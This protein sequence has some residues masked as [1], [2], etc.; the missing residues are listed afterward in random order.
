MRDNWINSKRSDMYNDEN[1]V[2]TFSNIYSPLIQVFSGSQCLR[3]NCL[4][5]SWMDVQYVSS[6]FF[7][8]FFFFLILAFLD[9]S[10]HAYPIMITPGSSPLTTW[11]AIFLPLL[12]MQ[13]VSVFHSQLFLWRETWF[14][15]AYI[16]EP[17]H[18]PSCWP[19]FRWIFL[20]RVSTPHL[21][22]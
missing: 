7:P 10:S 8:F 11:C 13:T 1:S 12:E 17:G 15:F 3:Y 6:V 5:M 21:I 2:V 18:N 14:G 19:E 20:D 22:S 16:V 4:Y 9:C